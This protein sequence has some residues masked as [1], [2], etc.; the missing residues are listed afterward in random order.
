MV[1]RM[2]RRMRAQGPDNSQ[3][4][5]SVTVTPALE[6]PAAETSVP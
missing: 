1:V 6:Q 3:L 4:A 2:A 5:V